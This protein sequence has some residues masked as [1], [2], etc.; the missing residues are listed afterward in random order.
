MLGATPVYSQLTQEQIDNLAEETISK[1][2][3]AGLAIGI[4]KDGHVFYSKGFGVKSVN[5]NEKVNENSAFAIASNS[6]AFTTTAL[7]LLVERDM[8]K[9]DDKVVDI[10]PEFRMYDEYVT[11]HFNIQDLLTHRSGLGLGAGDLMFIPPGTNFTMQD[12]VTSFQ[13]FEPQSDFR[14]SYDYD[15]LLYMV[16][17]EVIER[18]S[19]KS[20]ADFLEENIFLPL[21]MDNTTCLLSDQNDDFDI[22]S[23]HLTTGNVLVELNHFQKSINEAAGG[24]YSNVSDLCRWMLVHLNKGKY[25]QN[26][27]LELFTVGSQREMWKIH[28]SFITYPDERYNFHF[29]GYGLGWELRDIKG[30]MA[31]YH[32]GLLPGM[33]SQIILIPDIDLGIVVLINTASET[34]FSPTEAIAF[35]ILDDYL[36]LD[37]FNWMDKIYQSFQESDSEA[38][39]IVNATWQKV[40]QNAVKIHAN[41]YTGIYEDP[42]FGN[43]E[44][45]ESNG[46]LWFKSYRSPLLNGQLQLYENDTFAIKWEYQDLNGDAFVIFSGLDAKKTQFIE[47][48]GI[49]PNIDFS[50]D[51]QDL[52]LQRVE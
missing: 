24:I 8:L 32:G 29:S 34:G 38:D 30:N 43:V 36:G 48:K 5:T 23:P 25:G 33:A 3:V 14:A 45:F 11:N 6:K 20:Y 52:D 50:F 28:N 15:N 7:A 40:E 49:S 9:W 18:V 41:K 27:E 10:I 13:Y 46:K 47:I 21:K 2:N 26:L 37:D 44:V 19:G 39:S 4:V 12:V 35:T 1:F 31:A 42:W 51:F 22:A 16:A 17:G